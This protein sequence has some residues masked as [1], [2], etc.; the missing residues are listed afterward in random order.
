MRGQM[1]NHVAIH[2]TVELSEKNEIEE[3]EKFEILSVMQAMTQAAGMET[4][5]ASMT[6]VRFE[7]KKV[8][9]AAETDIFEMVEAN[10]HFG[11]NEGLETVEETSEM[12]ETM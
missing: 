10:E 3:T 7:V 2:H 9:V 6:E 5:E 11:R 1:R 4:I 8:T 12:T